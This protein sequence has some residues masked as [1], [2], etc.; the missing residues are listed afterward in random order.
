MDFAAQLHHDCDSCPGGCASYT[1]GGDSKHLYP[2]FVSFFYFRFSVILHHYYFQYLY[3]NIW[4]QF[5][6]AH[7]SFS[8]H[9]NRAYITTDFTVIN[10]GF[11]QRTVKRLTFLFMILNRLTYLEQRS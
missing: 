9:F 11:M 4:S 3:N 10:M 5:L 6:Y 2:L 7:I 1:R 8:S